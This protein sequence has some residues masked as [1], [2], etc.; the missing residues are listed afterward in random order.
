MIHQSATSLYPIRYFLTTTN[1]K[2]KLNSY[3]LKKKTYQHENKRQEVREKYQ[4][5]EFLKR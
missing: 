1:N 5:F 2:T 4:I 3:K